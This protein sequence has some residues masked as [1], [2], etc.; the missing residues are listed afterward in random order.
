MEYFKESEFACRCC[1]QLPPSA[2]ENIRALVDNVL[3]PARRKLGKPVFVNSGYRCEKHNKEVGGV[4]NSQ[5]LRGEAADLRIDGKPEKLARI[6]VENG[7]Y[8]QVI[9]YPTFVHV[10]Y[11]KNGVNRK[12]ILKKTASGYQK[13]SINDIK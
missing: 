10:S 13:I 6:I 7:V 9:V 4:T 3:D 5:H 12:Q 1:R 2:R 11:K 8:D